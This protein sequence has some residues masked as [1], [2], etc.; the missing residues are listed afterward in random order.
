MN[1]CQQIQSATRRLGEW[2]I[3]T[4]GKAVN[5]G[6]RYGLKIVGENPWQYP[7]DLKDPSK[8]EHEDLI[9]SISQSEPIN[10]GE[11]VAESTL[12]AIMGRMSAYTGREV[13]WEWIRNASEE[14]LGPKEYTWGSFDPEPGKTELA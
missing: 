12:T 5:D 10:D 1:G 11:R 14:D 8:T 4:K 3:G 2:I 7:G 6:G 13:S 9:K